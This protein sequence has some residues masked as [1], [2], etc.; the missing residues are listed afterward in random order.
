MHVV[1][2]R[3][4]FLD[5]FSFFFLSFFHC[6]PLIYFLEGVRDPNLYSSL[7]GDMIM[8]NVYFAAYMC[9]YVCIYIFWGEIIYF[10]GDKEDIYFCSTQNLV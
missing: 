10:G 2:H 6:I 9:M 7:I 5:F 1:I 3:N 4:S 8:G